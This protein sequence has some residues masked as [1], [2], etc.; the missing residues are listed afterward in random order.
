MKRHDIINRVGS[1]FL[2]A[3][4][5][6][7]DEWSYLQDAGGQTKLKEYVGVEKDITHY[8]LDIRLVDEKSNCAILVETKHRF[9]SSDEAQLAAYVDEEHAMFP[10]HNVVAILADTDDDKVKVWKQNVDS[11]SELKQESVLQSMEHYVSLFKFQKQNNRE[12]VMKNTV[13]LNELLQTYNIGVDIRSQLVGSCLLYIK[14]KVGKHEKNS[15][16]TNTDIS[17]LEKEMK[18]KDPEVIR[19]EIR[20]ELKKLLQKSS[21]KNNSDSELNVNQKVGLL[22][23]NVFENQNVKS[24]DSDKWASILGGTLGGVYRYINMNSAEGQDILNLFFVTFN[25]YSRSNDRNQAFTPDHITNFMAKLTEVG[26]NTVVLDPTCGSGSFLVQS[27]VM[28][29]NDVLKDPE[30]T[31]DEKNKKMDSIKSN[32]MFGIE[33]DE[34]VY[35]LATTNMLLHGDGN[36]NVK[37]GNCFELEDF[38]ESSL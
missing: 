1:Q 38:N 35:G 5:E 31:D 19:T 26:P 34:K 16:I 20:S 2:K 3:N 36:S 13:K 9:K 6:S 24:L 10:N 23:K 15:Y 14:N 18:E 22:D 11:E 33:L 8:K 7:S 21:K 29:L 17:E 12:K 25:K 32:N 37:Q 27:M 4:L 28:E 30:L